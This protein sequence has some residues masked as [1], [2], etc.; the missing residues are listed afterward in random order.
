MGNFTRRVI[1]FIMGMVVMLVTLLG[2]VAGTMYWA[3]K[4]LS[5]SKIGVMQDDNSGIADATIV[6]LVALVLLVQ[7]DPE[8][9]TIAKL[10]EQ[11]IDVLQLLGTLGVDLSKADSADYENLKN[12]SPLL[13]FSGEGLYQI[14]FST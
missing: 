8:S 2:G 5:L 4:N 3:F 1:A 9:F 7:S 13:L 12:I 6:D 11:G 14:S 10:E